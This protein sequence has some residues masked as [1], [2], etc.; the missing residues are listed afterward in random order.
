M[1]VGQFIWIINDK[2][3]VALLSVTFPDIEG[4]K[5]KNYGNWTP[6]RLSHSIRKLLDLV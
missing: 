3:Y 4:P 6:C 2:I 1:T 5:F